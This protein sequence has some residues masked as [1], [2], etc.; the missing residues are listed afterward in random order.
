MTHRAQ[1]L[2]MHLVK[3]LQPLTSACSDQ[4]DSIGR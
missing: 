1:A 4:L 2:Q 3:D